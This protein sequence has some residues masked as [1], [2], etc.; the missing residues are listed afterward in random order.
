MGK[1]GAVALVAATAALTAACGSGGGAAPA[2]W[3]IESDVPGTE[4][5]VGPQRLGATPLRLTR[6]QFESMG[7]IWPADPSKSPVGADGWGEGLFTGEEGEQETRLMI[8]VPDE[9]ADKYLSI[10]TP[11]GRRNKIAAAE[12]A[13]G[14]TRCRVVPVVDETGLKLVL[15]APRSRIGATDAYV[16]L[17]FSIEYMGEKYIKGFRP[18]VLVLLGTF[19]TPWNRRSRTVF[20]LDRDWS[21][22]EPKKSLKTTISLRTPSVAEDY[23]V[24]AVLRLYEGETGEALAIKPVHSNSALVRVR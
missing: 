5:F 14:G 9:V 22:W 11:W 19:R 4:V 20:K 2:S 18:E 1:L 7:L 8:R 6:R 10:E 21:T 23:S 12:A 13:A 15:A 24:F 16:T 17:D 3:R